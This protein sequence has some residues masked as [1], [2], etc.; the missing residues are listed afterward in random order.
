LDAQNLVHAPEAVNELILTFNVADYDANW[1]GLFLSFD[2]MTH[3]LTADSEN[4][5][6]VRGSDMDPWITLYN[7]EDN[8][9]SNG[10]YKKVEP[11]DILDALGFGPQNKVKLTTSLQVKFT[12]KGADESF[13]AMGDGG[14]SIDNIQLSSGAVL[15]V[16]LISFYA[17]KEGEDALLTWETATELNNSH[18]NVQVATETVQGEITA[19]RTIGE[20]QGAGTTSIPQAYRFTDNELGKVGNRYYRLEQVDY[21]GK[22]DYSK[23]RVLRFTKQ[24]PTSL[25][26]Y[27][28]PVDEVVSIQVNAMEQG[29]V[30]IAITDVTGKLLDLYNFDVERGLSLKK[31]ELDNRYTDGVYL[32]NATIDGARTTKKIIKANSK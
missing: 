14:Y 17:E 12:Q 2:Y 4:K 15:P 9:L 30:E 28:N 19:F 20:L 21:D 11:L 3:Y 8:Q 31:I 18:F 23:T 7:I 26:V 6:S 16:E 29:P 27:P 5:V 13:D 1:D 24:H 10:T 32:I 22:I 25:S